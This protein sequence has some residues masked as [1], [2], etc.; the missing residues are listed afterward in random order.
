MEK[1]VKFIFSPLA[2]NA[3]LYLRKAKEEFIFRGGR[4]GNIVEG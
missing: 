4:V 1:V 3:N 2:L